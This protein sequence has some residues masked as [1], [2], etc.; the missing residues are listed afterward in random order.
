MRQNHERGHDYRMATDA[1]YRR[2]EK[3][4]AKTRAARKRLI[5]DN[6]AAKCASQ[7]NTPHGG[8]LELH[9]IKGDLSGAS[10]YRVMCAKHNR[11]AAGQKG[12]KVRV[13]GQARVVE[14]RFW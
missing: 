7:A 8:P 11:A 3:H 4:K 10:G 1:N 13:P 2:R 14:L 6:P 9:H 12:Q 5:E